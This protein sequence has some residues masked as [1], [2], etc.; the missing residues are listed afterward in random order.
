MNVAGGDTDP[1]DP[2]DPKN[3]L[4][5]QIVNKPFNVDVLSFGNDNITPTS[6]SP[7]VDLN[8]SIVEL[9]PDG[10]CSDANISA[11]Y[12]LH[13]NTTDKYKPATV[14]ATKASQNAAFKMKTT[15]ANLCS[16]DRFAIRPASYSMDA[17]E[18][19]LVGGKT[20]N[21]TFTATP[22]SLTTPALHYDQNMT[23]A[24]DKNGTTQ[25]VIPPGCLIADVGPKLFNDPLAYNLPFSDG[26]VV[27]LVKYPDIGDVN[28]TITDNSWSQASGDQSKGDCVLGSASNIEDVNGKLGC[29]AQGARV[30]TFVPDKFT[31]L[32]SLANGSANG[33]YT[34]IS[35]EQN[36]S[37]SLFFTTSA[38]LF[39]GGLANNYTAG[40]FAK[41][42]NTTLSLMNNKA[43]TWSDS[44]NRIN[45]FDD[46]NVTSQRLSQVGPVATFRSG[47]G[48][49][50]NGTAPIT[51]MF[52]FD[53][54]QTIPDNSFRIARNDFNITSVID[55][56]GTT[57]SD[58][59]RTNDLNASF[60]YGRIIP[61][62]IR[63]FGSVP[64]SANGWYEVFNTQTLGGV[65]LLPS[66]N[67][68]MWYIN[69][70]HSDPLDGEA[71]VT[72]I[73]TGAVNIGGV[74]VNGEKTYNFAA[75]AAGSI[76]YS[77][78]A[79]IDTDPWLWY[80]PNALL[81][82]DP[83]ATNLEC[84]THPCFNINVVPAIGATGSAK[85]ETEGNKSNKSSTSGGGGGWKSTT[86][87]APAI[88]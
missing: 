37:A 52:N 33:S 55:Q 35:N 51:F 81:Y 14:I 18:T 8:L 23:G 9:L 43:L 63:V 86:D 1:I 57:G 17:N 48:N 4:Y 30:F 79:H 50:T 42:I 64:Y 77:A 32:F 29:M 65:A 13:F 21:F 69:S 66:K 82:S 78:K 34:Y 71:N 68:A 15:T 5:T 11:V 70:Q 10:N 49:F 41:D 59:D 22:E 36:M 85:H 53:R 45:Y 3:A 74:V 7:A 28:F 76:P 56:N 61:R 58:F 46:Y 26:Q 27:A 16:R 6:P 83:S 62:D 67:D 19:K 31:S 88:R 54:N 2:L 47:E 20:Y 87:Y 25:L 40:C 60:V 73:N 72:R 39:G 24:A 84:T 80:G 12:P 38:T 44:Q 75:I